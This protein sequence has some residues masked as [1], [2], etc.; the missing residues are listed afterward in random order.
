LE[1]DGCDNRSLRS[2]SP[3]ERSDERSRVKMARLFGSAMMANDDST[4][5]I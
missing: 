3:T 1:T 4:T 5:D 2:I